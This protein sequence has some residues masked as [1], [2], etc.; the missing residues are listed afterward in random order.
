MGA[1]TFLEASNVVF[2]GTEVVDGTGTGVVVAT[3]K[4]TQV[5]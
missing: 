5:R 2:M 1:A 3:G 4:D